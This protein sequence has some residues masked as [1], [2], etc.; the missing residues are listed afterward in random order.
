LNGSRWATRRLAQGGKKSALD[1]SLYRSA[2]E[3]VTDGVVV[4]EADG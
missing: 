3:P 4:E 1:A 2:A